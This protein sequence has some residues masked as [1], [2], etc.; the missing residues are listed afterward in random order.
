[1]QEGSWL[2]MAVGLS[3]RHLG[4][5]IGP[6]VITLAQGCDKLRF[7]GR[8]GFGVRVGVWVRVGVRVGARARVR[9]KVRARVRT[10]C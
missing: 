2:C 3:A 10:I 4:L 1:M 5:G 8:V 9:D 7:R 6:E